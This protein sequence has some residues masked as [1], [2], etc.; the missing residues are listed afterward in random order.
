MYKIVVNEKDETGVDFNA[1]VDRPAHM[2]G[3]ISFSDAANYSVNE[4]KRMVTGVMI[5]VGTPIY[6]R[7][8]QYGEHLVIF[9]A[10]TVDVIRKKFF[11]NGFNQNLNAMH[12]ANQVIRDGV[13]LIDS[14]V[15]SNSDPKMPKAPAAFDKMRLMDGTWIACYYVEDDQVWADVKAGK[16]TGFSVEG[17]FD[18]RAIKAKNTN[19]FDKMSGKN[20]K[21][22]W[23]RFGIGSKKET[24]TEA[25][26]AD[27]TI[28]FYEGE[29]AVG[30]AI[31]VEVEGEKVPAPEGEHEVTLADSTVKIVTLDGT[32]T[33]TEIADFMAEDMEDA[34]A[35]GELMREIVTGIDERFKATETSNAA[36][37]KALNGITAEINAFKKDGKFSAKPLK[38]EEAAKVGFRDILANAKKKPVQK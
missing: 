27:G 25:T 31:T 33:V 11:K 4:E 17:W 6:R 29:L 15:I 13:T 16:Y 3:W 28:L 38:T 19:K 2:K 20:K 36:I 9:D 35:V 30:T 21:T 10:K 12:D 22:I 5:S 37:L 34:A 14:Y 7:D 8:D 24:F 32:G 23:D 18:K 1:M 26:T